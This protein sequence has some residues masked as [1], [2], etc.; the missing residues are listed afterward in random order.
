MSFGGWRRRRPIGQLVAICRER[1]FTNTWKLYRASTGRRRFGID[2]TST[3]F[4]NSFALIR[5]HPWNPGYPWSPLAATAWQC[6]AIAGH[7]LGT[8]FALHIPDFAIQERNGQPMKPLFTYQATCAFAPALHPVVAFGA[9]SPKMA[10][11]PGS[12]LGDDDGDSAISINSFAARRSEV[13]FLAD[14]ETY[15]RTNYRSCPYVLPTDSFDRFG[16]AFRFGRQQHRQYENRKFADIAPE[17]ERLWSREGFE[18][19]LTWKR[20]LPAVRDAFNRTARL[21]G[22]LADTDCPE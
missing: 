18:A 9:F 8:R 6:G 7:R 14:E 4:P 10:F 1:N 17:L 22:S 13:V 5:V 2:R 21:C 12:T 20:A 3:D 16:P 15:W 19:L 11:D